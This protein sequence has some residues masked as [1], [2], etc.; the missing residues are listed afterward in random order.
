M[1]ASGSFAESGNISFVG[2]LSPSLASGPTS[3]S[4]SG[5]GRLTVA[6]CGN[7][8][9]FEGNVC[10]RSGFRQRYVRPTPLEGIGQRVQHL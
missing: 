9:V 5:N 7:G 10:N 6:G 2:E 8:I 1:V 3:G 4:G